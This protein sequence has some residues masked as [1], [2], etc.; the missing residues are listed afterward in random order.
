MRQRNSGS[1]IIKNNIARTVYTVT[2]T[3]QFFFFF[4]GSGQLLLINRVI[5]LL[6]F[7]LGFNFNVFKSVV[8]VNGSMRVFLGAIKLGLEL[9]L[10]KEFKI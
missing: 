8:Y 3:K 2:T 6:L 10:S 9:E 5:A 4:G 7:L 1:I